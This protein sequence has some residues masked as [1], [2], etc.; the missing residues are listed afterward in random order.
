MNRNLVSNPVPSKVSVRMTS[1]ATDAVRRHDLQS[2][3]RILRL[4]V[5]TDL[6][7]IFSPVLNQKHVKTLMI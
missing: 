3:S 6:Q 2:E 5:N 7:K 1:V 4:L